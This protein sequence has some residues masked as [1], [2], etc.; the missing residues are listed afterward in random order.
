[1]SSGAEGISG[2]EPRRG[3]RLPLPS[4]AVAFRLALV[5]VAL[6]ALVAG[7]CGDAGT[8]AEADEETTTTSYVPPMTTTSYIPPRT[9]D[10]SVSM[11]VAEQ[12]KTKPDGTFTVVYEISL[13]ILSSNTVAYPYLVS[14]TFAFASGVVVVSTSAA[15]VAPVERPPP[16]FTPAFDGASVPVLASIDSPVGGVQIYEL[17]V[18]V[19]SRAVP[20]G[21]GRDCILDPGESGT[22]LLNRATAFNYRAGGW[23]GPVAAA[24]ASIP[25]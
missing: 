9:P 11:T 25:T 4:G 16:S 5:G 2:L 1:M 19:D 17:T 20:D 10:V 22:G 14:D 7:G 23:T 24:C 15:F 18:T 21:A 3:T 12:P 13:Q 8:S 6:T